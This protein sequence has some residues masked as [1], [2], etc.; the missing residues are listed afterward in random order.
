MCASIILFLFIIMWKLSPL[1][2]VNNSNLHHSTRAE[3]FFTSFIKR[4]SRQLYVEPHTQVLELSRWKELAQMFLATLGV[5][6][7]FLDK[8]YAFEILLP[9]CD[10]SKILLTNEEFFHDYEKDPE[11][12]MYHQIIVD[13]KERFKTGYYTQPWLSLTKPD[14]SRYDFLCEHLIDHGFYLFITMVYE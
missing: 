14:N 8:E 10:L 3:R 7:D 13:K 5:E 6:N 9:T 12:K 4:V 2:K 11:S 1:F